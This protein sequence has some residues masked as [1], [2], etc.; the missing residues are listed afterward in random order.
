[1][2]QDFVSS[3][4]AAL[5][6]FSQ[7][8]YNSL[9]ADLASALWAIAALIFVAM[10]INGVLQIREIGFGGYVGWIIRA[11]IIIGMA[12]S[13][14]FFQPIYQGIS[15]LPDTIAGELTGTT[16]V[17]EALDDIALQCFLMGQQAI[18]NATWGLSITGAIL[19]VVGAVIVAFGTGMALIAKGGLAVLLGL[20]PVFIATLLSSATAN[21]FAAWAK[22][23]VGLIMVIVVLTGIVSLI[24]AL[25]S[26][27]LT[28]VEDVNNMEASGRFLAICI[29]SIVMLTQIP[30]L[31]GG[32]SGAIVSASSGLAVAT[33]AA[34]AARSALGT[35]SDGARGAVAG[36]KTA[37]AMAS[38]ARDGTGVRDS[39][40]RAMQARRD[41]AHRA[42]N[43][44][45][46]ARQSYAADRYRQSI[47][48][49]RANKSS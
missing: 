28:A 24:Q 39:A 23:T 9:A 27:E 7:Q 49:A 22:T 29:V 31:A 43:Q 45:G 26:S 10:L 15:S 37:A 2:I 11:T 47:R 34:A 14:S 17:W 30:S 46:A 20:A 21:I 35:A 42:R 44:D 32:M 40:S 19:W 33:G 41:I 38:A 12:S 1:M 6:N 3:I 36:G 5:N 4:E 16:N 18:E 8:A 48:Q 13:W 25:F